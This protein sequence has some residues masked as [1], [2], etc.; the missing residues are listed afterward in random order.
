M[1]WG[2]RCG[3]ELELARLQRLAA[4]L[5]DDTQRLGPLP[6]EP[7]AAV[8]VKQIGANMGQ[9]PTVEDRHEWI[10]ELATLSPTINTILSGTSL[11]PVSYRDSSSGEIT[12]VDAFNLANDGDHN[13]ALGRC[14][15]G[16]SAKG[17]KSATLLKY[18]TDLTGGRNTYGT[19]S[20]LLAYLWFIDHKV[21]FEI[22]IPVTG[23]QILNPQGSEL[24]GNLTALSNV[25]FDIKGFGFQETLIER[26]RQRLEMDI[27]GKWVAV[28]GSWDVAVEELQELLQQKQYDQ[29]LLDLKQK[30]VVSRGVLQF[31]VRE[32]RVVQVSHRLVDPYLLARENSEYVFRFAKQF[33]R[34]DPFIL[35]LAYHPWFGGLS[36]NTDFAGSTSTFTR[37]FARR[38]FMQHLRDTSSVYD[39]TKG[40]ASRLISGIAFLNISQIAGASHRSQ[41][42]RLYLNPN[43]TNP[44]SML[45]VDILRNHD[46][47]SVELDAFAF[48]NY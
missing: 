12:E 30:P 43:A 1:T 42:M 8:H 2:R 14:F 23:A 35:I 5:P 26:L 47:M 36:L 32:K 27:P 13:R 45:T 39:V 9:V 46:P 19:T 25:F 17:V 24:D 38:T 20:E 11:S 29:L 41:T 3:G 34:T 44:L 33:C 6:G 10:G 21:P 48:D 16:L 4:L 40:E 37:A 28:E 22:Q 18:L 15:D 7:G 31:I